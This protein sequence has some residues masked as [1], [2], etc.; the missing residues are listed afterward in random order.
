MHVVVPECPARQPF[1]FYYSPSA[2][3]KGHLRVTSLSRSAE[4]IIFDSTPEYVTMTLKTCVFFLSEEN[5]EKSTSFSYF[6]RSR[7]DF[8]KVT[9]NLTEAASAIRRLTL[10]KKTT[11]DL[12]SEEQIFVSCS[13]EDHGKKELRILRAIVASLNA[14][15]VVTF[16]STSRISFV[17]VLALGVQDPYLHYIPGF[18]ITGITLDFVPLPVGRH[19]KLYHPLQPFDN[20]NWV[21]LQAIFCGVRVENLEE[22]TFETQSSAGKLRRQWESLA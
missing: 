3:Q 21:Y 12:V 4:L 11:S 19:H 14:S 10:L 7:P 18:W 5:K 2:F 8:P 1:E 9:I 13:L 17:N 20:H 15:T 22:A 16:D 6:A